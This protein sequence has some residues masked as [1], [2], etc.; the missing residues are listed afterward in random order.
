VSGGGSSTN[1]DGGAGTY[2]LT[3]IWL[4]LQFDDGRSKR[5][6]VFLNAATGESA[7]VLMINDINLAQE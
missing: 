3:D 1:V 2:T 5:L 4:N 7:A 6:P